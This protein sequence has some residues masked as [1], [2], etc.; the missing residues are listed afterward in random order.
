M[1][2]ACEAVGIRAFPTWLINDRL[3]EGELTLDGLRAELEAP[4]GAPS[5]NAMPVT[6]EPVAFQ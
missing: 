1:A 4:I 6:E 2:D 3:I 5:P